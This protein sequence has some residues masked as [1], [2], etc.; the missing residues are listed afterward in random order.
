MNF[1]TKG[2][3]VDCV[4]PP[5]ESNQ[6]SPTDT[7]PS[8]RAELKITFQEIRLLEDRQRRIGFTDVDDD[9]GKPDKT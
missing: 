3:E 8:I 6:T 1:T 5:E 9:A 2:G 4:L 7:A